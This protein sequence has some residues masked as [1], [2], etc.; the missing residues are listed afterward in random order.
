MS[1][2]GKRDQIILEDLVACARNAALK[3]GRAATLLDEVIA[4]VKR[5]N[6]HATRA[7][8]PEQDAAKI[9]SVFRLDWK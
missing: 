9:V 1:A 2:N 4:A 7:G 6:D 3:R 5:W 8:V